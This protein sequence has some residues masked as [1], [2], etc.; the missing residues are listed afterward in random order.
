MQ[1]LAAIVGPTASGKTGLAI[2]AAQ[3]IGAEI[4]SC[5]SMQ[6]YRGMDIGTAKAS[7][8]EQQ[9]IPHHLIDI[10]DVDQDFSTAA[11]QRLA[12]KQI[13][14]LNHRHIIP[15]MVGGTGLY[16]QSVAD[17]YQFFPMDARQ[18]VREQ[19][20]RQVETNGLDWVYNRLKQVDPQYAALISCNDRKRIIR[21]LEVYEITGRTF[22]SFQKCNQ[23]RYL[24]A[25][26]GLR[27]QR[28]E[29]Y[30][31]IDQRVDQMMERGLIEEVAALMKKYHNCEELN[32]MQA[33][34]YKQAIAYLQGFISRE[35]MVEEVKR[36]TRRY[37]KRQLTWFNKDKRIFW[38][39]AGENHREEEIVQ[40][41]CTYIEGRFNSV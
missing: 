36:E 41:I 37:A 12:K 26:V 35:A 2:K 10:V 16:Y 32:S 25:A 13:E 20:N 40:N 17:D 34:G 38:V 22:T 5:D 28:M 39:D 31:R 6:I 9:V 21:A 29:L 7:I 8:R 11:Y 33:L 23:N 27:L 19:L 30:H 18:N 4:L 24:L 1:K 3:I 15:L 14:Y